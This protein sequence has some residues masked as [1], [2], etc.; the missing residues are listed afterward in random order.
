MNLRACVS[1]ERG[2]GEG[3]GSQALAPPPVL[4]LHK[5]VTKTLKRLLHIPVNVR[6]QDFSRFFCFRN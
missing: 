4:F 2:D 5:N 3:A 6:K 1:E